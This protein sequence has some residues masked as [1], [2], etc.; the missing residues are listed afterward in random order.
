MT[1]E[2]KDLINSLIGQIAKIDAL[3]IFQS[4]K[5]IPLGITMLEDN[6]FSVEKFLQLHEATIKSFMQELEG[7]YLLPVNRTCLIRDREIDIIDSL[8]QYLESLNQRAL[9]KMELLLQQIIDY[10][11]Y[12]GFWEKGQLQFISSLAREV[13]Q[14]KK[15]MIILEDRLKKSLEESRNLAISLKEDKKS[16]GTFIRDKDQDYNSKLGEIRAKV[17]LTESA[18]NNIIS[19]S[20][21]IGDLYTSA[22]TNATKISE[23]LKV[24]GENKN[25]IF[26]KIAKADIKLDEEKKEYL[27]LKAEHQDLISGTQDLSSALKDVIDSAKDVNQKL[28][29]DHIAVER[30]LGLATGA[31]LFVKFGERKVAIMITARWWLISCLVSL[32]MLLGAFWTG[33]AYNILSK[34]VSWVSFGSNV[35]RVAPFTLPLFFSVRQYNKER[36]FA[37]E[38]AFKSSIAITLEAFRSLLDHD[39]VQQ[40]ALITSATKEIFTPPKGVRENES[41]LLFRSR[42]IKDMLKEIL[43]VIKHPNSPL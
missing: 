19:S 13:D 7:A 24:L 17:K 20:K 10:A 15:N 37:E 27:T 14:M 8:K 3:E 32:L 38:Y 34:D 16:I 4:L 26:A 2:E 21:L 29:Q 43:S 40:S 28:S 31:S 30:L 33:W 23:I 9:S 39:K 22:Q 12:W 6:H 18:S 5:R 41:G 11:K 42:D 1:R 25:D 35:L 36:T